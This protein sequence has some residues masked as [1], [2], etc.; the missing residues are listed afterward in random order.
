MALKPIGGPAPRVTGPVKVSPPIKTVGGPVKPVGPIPV[1]HK[2]GK[3]KKTGL[4]MV[5]KG[6]TVIP[7]KKK[8]KK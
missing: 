8:A 5:K 3:V 2:G 4:A 6:E 1:Y 7:A